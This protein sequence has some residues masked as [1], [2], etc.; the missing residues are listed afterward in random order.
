MYIDV[1]KLIHT[2]TQLDPIEE[3]SLWMSDEDIFEV[4][5]DGMNLGFSK[6]PNR[7]CEILSYI[8][9]N[10]LQIVFHILF[11]PAW[12]L[13]ARYR[14]KKGDD[15]EDWHNEDFIQSAYHS[16]EE[17]I[18]RKEFKG[19]IRFFDATDFEN[20]QYDIEGFKKKFYELN[21]LHSKED[22]QAFLDS[23]TEKYQTIELPYGIN[24]IGNNR[25]VEKWRSICETINFEGRTVLDLGGYFGYYCFKAEEAGAR[26][27]VLWDLLSNLD[28]V[29]E[30]RN[31]KRSN[32][33]IQRVNISETPIPKTYD[34]IFYLMFC[35]T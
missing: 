14:E 10:N 19:E 5:L 2:G 6:N 1:G 31:R 28:T 20:V 30:L 29:R 13:V 7:D 26:E 11:A 9:S 23:L 17:R 4:I 18:K 3:L 22:T 35:I 27:V 16:I 15:L 34:I 32:I 21:R 12:M 24:R 8:Y 25:D 33:V